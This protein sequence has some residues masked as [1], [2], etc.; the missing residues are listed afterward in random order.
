MIRI[1]IVTPSYNQAHFLEQTIQSVLSQNYENLQ[2]IIIDGGS[3]DGSVEIIEKY[4]RYLDYWNSEPDSGQSEAINKGLWRCNGE[5]FNWINSDDILAEGCLDFVA[6]AFANP[7]I[8]IVGGSYELFYNNDIHNGKLIKYNSLKEIYHTIGNTL[9]HQPSTFIRMNKI[10]EIGFIN[11]SLKYIMDQDLWIRYLSAFG[12][13]NIQITDKVLAHFRVHSNSKTEK[14]GY[15]KFWDE[16][17]SYFYTIAKKAGLKKQANAM[18][19]KNPGITELN[20]MSF[21]D[22]IDPKLFPKAINSQFEVKARQYIYDGDKKGA[23]LSIK[24]ITE[25]YLFLLL[26]LRII[27]DPL[28]RFIRKYIPHR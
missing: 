23:L 24:V 9:M 4:S 28:I 1:S 26:Y 13:E 6:K 8:D 7:A 20:L 16:R 11:Q 15:D 14:F 25:K 22:P 17:D 12:Q 18:R 27:A 19:V 10:R 3:T 2:Y 5:V 21:V